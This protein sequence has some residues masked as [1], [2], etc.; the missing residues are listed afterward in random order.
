MHLQPHKQQTMPN[1]LNSTQVY[2]H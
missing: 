2:S 1:L